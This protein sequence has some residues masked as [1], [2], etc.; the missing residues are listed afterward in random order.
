MTGGVAFLRKSN[1]KKNI[2]DEGSTALKTA[3]TVDL[4]YIVDTVD[5]VY[6]FDMVYTVDMEVE[7]A[8][9]AD[10]AEWVEL[11]TMGIGYMALW[12]F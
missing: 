9:M 10:R 11:N 3:D 2:R 8:E 6:T 5:M 4:D 7:E 12:G 1:V